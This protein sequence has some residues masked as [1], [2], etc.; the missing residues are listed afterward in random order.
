MN[1]K[2]R[3][4]NLVAPHPANR[5]AEKSGAFSPRRREEKAAEI[6][7]AV[8]QDAVT[9]LRS[10]LLRVF[11]EKKA[12]VELLA[13]DLAD[14][15]VSDREGKPRRT[16]SMYAKGLRDWQEA[17]D[18][19]RMEFGVSVGDDSYREEPWSEVEGL[20]LLRSFAHDPSMAAAS[21]IAAIRLLLDRGPQ[22]EEDARI[23]S[24]GMFFSELAELT[25]AELS[26][27]LFALTYPLT[28]METLTPEQDR[29]YTL[30]SL[31]KEAGVMDEAQFEE[32]RELLVATRDQPDPRATPTVGTLTTDA[33]E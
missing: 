5:N 6:R 23:R 12:F 1:K 27:E 8:E 28:T 10:D 11:A 19:V 20:A 14:R 15:G 22:A 29:L 17:G 4:E 24:F 18:R 9:Y 31:L 13:R 2:G 7:Q 25:D 32:L 16:V 26:R 3:K 33:T 30:L 21:R